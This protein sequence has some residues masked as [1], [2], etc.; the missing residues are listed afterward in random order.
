M[1]LYKFHVWN[2][3]SIFCPRCFFID[4]KRNMLWRYRMPTQY[5][6]YLLYQ[7]EERLSTSRLSTSRL[8]HCH[9]AGL[10]QYQVFIQNADLTR[11]RQLSSHKLM[12]MPYDLI[13]FYIFFML[14]LYG[15]Y[16]Y[17][18]LLAI[19][20]PLEPLEFCSTVTTVFITPAINMIFLWRW[21]EY[22]YGSRMKHVR[23]H[24]DR[25]YLKHF[26]T[27]TQYGYSPLSIEWLTVG[28]MCYERIR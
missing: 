19:S 14:R 2:N 16:P 25:P 18:H 4:T 6:G 10:H 1:L 23:F 13:V 26:I 15:W 3:D 17:C 7:I 24:I 9:I 28:Y 12:I 20:I 8:S 11:N 5:D 21:N 22:V 27:N